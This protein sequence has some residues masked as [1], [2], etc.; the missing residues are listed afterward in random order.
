MA[1]N[2]RPGV[3]WPLVTL[4]IAAIVLLVF[5]PN[6]PGWLSGIM[7]TILVFGFAGYF[8]LSYLQKKNKTFF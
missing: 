4:M 5:L 1:L 8:V 3:S 2:K 7:G 6:L